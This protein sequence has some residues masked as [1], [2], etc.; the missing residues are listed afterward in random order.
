VTERWRALDPATGLHALE[1]K[2]SSGWCWRSTA[3]PLDGGGFLVVSPIRGTAAALDE[4]G[5]AAAALAPNHFHHMGIEELAARNEGLLVGASAIAGKRLASKLRRAPVPLDAIRERLRDGVTLLEPPGLRTGEVW[6]RAETARGV[7]WSVCDA[8]F[9]VNAPV[10]G[11]TGL[12]LRMTSTVPGLRVG[13]TFRWLAVGDRK[14]YRAWLEARL[15]DDPPRILIPAHGDVVEGDDL[16][17][18]LAALAATL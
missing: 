18:R 13:S 6:L 5:P 9:N 15:R 14:A 2:A 11:G 10:R 16:P 1:K 17:E 4:L 12:V 7:A 8:F 3:V